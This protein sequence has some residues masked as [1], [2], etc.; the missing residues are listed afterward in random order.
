MTKNLKK[1]ILL[2]AAELLVTNDY[3][4]FS[5]IAIQD[6]CGPGYSELTKQYRNFFVKNPENLAWLHNIPEYEHH[7]PNEEKRAY[8]VLMLL[9]FRESL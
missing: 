5:C 8:R 3:M 9:L 1:K 2:K 6:T 4:E 7:I